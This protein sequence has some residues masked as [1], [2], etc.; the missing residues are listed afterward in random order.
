MDLNTVRIFV[1]LSNTLSLHRR[2]LFSFR[3]HSV[4][5]AETLFLKR[6]HFTARQARINF[7]LNFTM[8]KANDAITIQAEKRESGLV[9]ISPFYCG[10]PIQPILFEFE[11]SAP[12]ISTSVRSAP[13]RSA[14]VRKAFVRLALLRLAFLRSALVRKTL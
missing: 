5:L 3:L 13:L 11:K 2:N 14:L 8:F 7:H 6:Y 10:Q 9:Q 1:F 4:R 12:I